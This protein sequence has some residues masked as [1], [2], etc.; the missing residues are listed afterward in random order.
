[1]TV[2][3]RPRWV[4][5]KEASKR[6]GLTELTVRRKIQR[7]EL[8]ALQLGGPGCAVRILEDDLHRF[9]FGSPSEHRGP[10]AA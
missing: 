1:M 3:E 9:I 8:R 4:T 7:G 2:L 10:E 5:V 6:L